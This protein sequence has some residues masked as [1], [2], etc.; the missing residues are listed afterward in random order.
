MWVVTYSEVNLI[1]EALDYMCRSMF[2]CILRYL[3]VSL[4]CG[5]FCHTPKS[6]AVQQR[7]ACYIGICL[8]YK[9]NSTETVHSSPFV[10]TDGRYH[11]I[12][13]DLLPFNVVWCRFFWQNFTHS[14]SLM[15]AQFCYLFTSS[16]ST[17]LPSWFDLFTYSLLHHWRGGPPRRQSPWQTWALCS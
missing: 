12:G 15:T 16:Q 1:I 10:S 17:W 5:N 4:A 2:S 7:P 9:F 11:L 13:N 14:W 3:I 6:L 8:P